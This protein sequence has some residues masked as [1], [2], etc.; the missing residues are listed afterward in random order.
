MNFIKFSLI[1]LLS[2]ISSVYAET[3]SETAA[4]YFN[5]LKKKHYNTAATYFDPTALN[6]FRQTM[7]F[8]NEI[9]AEAQQEFFQ[10]FFGPGANQKSISELSDTDFFASF[11]RAVMAQAEA[12]GTINIEG[13]EILG[14]VMEG[15]D[16][17]HIVTRNRASVGKI[18]MESMEVISFKKKGN[19]WKL[20][21]SG[22][23]KGMANQLRS[24]FS[25][26]K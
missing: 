17:A 22:K 2:S 18:Y 25:R 23:I 12:A 3:A 11:L 13:I 5:V 24:A 8:I 4:E 7:S 6:D 26:Q 20:L 14:K 16:I 15:S 9:P 19:E 10:V 1:L 21:M